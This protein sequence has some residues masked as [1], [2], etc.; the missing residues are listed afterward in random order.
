MKRVVW[1]FFTGAVGLGL[2]TTD[3]VAQTGSIVGQVVDA[4]SRAPITQAQVFIPG[5]N[6]GSITNQNGRFTIAAVPVGS[7]TVRVERL[8]YRAVEL[9]VTVTA[10]QAAEVSFELATDVLGLDAVVVTGTAGASRRREI[11]STIEQINLSDQPASTNYTAELL[12]AA[13]P[14]VQVTR[15]AGRLGGGFDIRLRGNTSVS[16]SNQPIIYID[17]VRM[18]SKPFP[19]GRAPAAGTSGAAG[20]I[21]ANPLNSINPADIERI[22]VIKGSAAT[23]LYGT[24]A[25]AGVIQIFTKRGSSGAP[26][27]TLETQ[28]TTDRAVTIGPDPFPYHRIEPFLSTGYVG[29]YSASVRGGGEALQ[30]FASGRFE[31]GTGILPSDSIATYSVRSNF[32]FTP[33]SALQVQWNTSYTNTGQRNTPQGGNAAGLTH[34]AYRGYANYVTSEDPARLWQLFDQEARQTIERFSTGT[35][36]THSPL[37]NFTSRL[38]VGY[39]FSQQ[40][41]R[42]IRPLGF[43][44]FP[45]GSIY[46]DTWE[47]RLLTVDYVGSYSRS[48]TSDVLSTF[49]VGGQVVGE[50][51]LWLN[52]YGWRFSGPGS[53][54][55]SS[56]ANSIAVESKQKVWNAGI[57]VQ[58]VFDISDRYFLTLGL[59]VDGNS[60]FGS[61]FG[62]QPYPKVSGTWVLSEEGFWREGWGDIRLRA[63]YGQS[64]RAPSAF[65]A[66]Q[67]WSM[68][69]LGGRPGLIPQNLGGED[70]GPEV[71]REFETGFD[72]S[73]A[74][75]RI[76]GRVTFF[77]QVTTDALF[78]VQQ[79]PST[80]FI[81]SQRLNVGEILNS[82][83]EIS[84]NTT[85]I[86][87]R[88]WGVTAGVDVSTNHSEVL[89][90]GGIPPFTVAGAFQGGAWI[91]EGKPVPLIRTDF[92]R[93]GDKPGI[94]GAC[95]APAAVADP[96]LPCVDPQ[97]EYGPGQPTLTVM[98]N[99]AVR[100]PRGVNLSAAGEFR[101][102]HYSTESNFTAGGVQRSAWM[103]YCWE[104]YTNPYHGKVVDYAPPRA[105]QTLDLK[106]DTPAKFQAACSPNRFRAGLFTNRADF[107]KLRRLTAQVPVDFA[108]PEATRNAV[109][110][111]SVNNAWRWLHS[112]WRVGDPEME[113]NPNDLVSGGAG[114]APPPTWTF[115]ASLRVQF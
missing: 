108:F 51:E 50:E 53:P 86:A 94:P 8:G 84:L 76:D 11:G 92:V 20:G 44:L 13:A 100:L 105:D 90:L 113:V 72:G 55:V 52:G 115:S 49:S 114:S 93:N 67:T 110:T 112:D 42:M 16:M 87:R 34:N 39:D 1:M 40:R 28:H 81:G 59:R 101:G 35:T 91:I 41:M 83:W 102:G 18:Q 36:L 71:T 14:G 37:P 61:G 75:G 29:T 33:L 107:F 69:P 89:S 88:G 43:E 57:F 30:Y 2:W 58:N 6:L 9:E 60:T 26:D 104:F 4:G 82:G 95:S 46:N 12:Q 24:E 65:D 73:W 23:T 31:G 48:L 56:A 78:N 25:S 99:V 17:G 103:P 74:E 63:A 7:R 68:Q 79:V 70:L 111:L 66:V 21:Q 3:I 96:S 22:E 27:W 106:P 5:L 15:D 45:E 62:L 32:T 54:T 109:L 85:P 64:G 10:D 97:H 19:M 77:R 38:T 98:P 47:N 80:G